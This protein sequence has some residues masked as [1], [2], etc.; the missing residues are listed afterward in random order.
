MGFW[1]GAGGAAAISGASS[2][3][4]G[5]LG[6][7]DGGM[8]QRKQDARFFWQT[9]RDDQERFATQRADQLQ[10]AKEGAGW[11]MQDIIDTAGQNGIH[12]L[13][14]LGVAGSPGYTPVQG[15]SVQAPFGGPSEEDNNF[16]GDAVS[17]AMNTYLRVRQMDHKE[18]MDQAHLDLLTAQSKTA[19]AEA[20][21]QN[22]A[23]DAEKA[24][25]AKEMGQSFGPNL[26]GNTSPYRAYDEGDNTT[27]ILGI[28]LPSH[29]AQ[30]NEDAGGQILG[31][32]ETLRA[33]AGE[34]WN[35]KN[36]KKRS[37]A[38]AISTYLKTPEAK[39]KGGRL[40]VGD[41]E[42]WYQNFRWRAKASGYY[43]KTPDR[44][45]GISP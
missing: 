38:N 32:L 21:R 36:A 27:N 37:I 7:G 22:Y 31:G 6:K 23:A 5:L 17:D 42:R 45:F 34:W 26:P 18:Q 3:L 9:R 41:F 4:G 20:R 29:L 14:A 30:K 24:K 28:K 19:E 25:A 35:Q 2:L 44:G 12:P 33:A 16:L 40:T 13:A 39:K 11:Q 8:R 10:F 43:D 15:G 1:T